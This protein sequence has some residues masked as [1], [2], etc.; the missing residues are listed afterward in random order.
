MVGGVVS[1]VTLIVRLP[2]AVALPASETFN[3][4]RFA[5]RVAEQATAIDAVI[6]PLV[7]VIEEME[8]PRGTEVTVTIRL[9]AGVR[10]SLTVAIVCTAEGLSCWREIVAG[11]ICGG[12]FGGGGGGPLQPKKMGETFFS[13]V[14]TAA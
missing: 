3:P 14:P 1:A 7:L 11:L 13:F 8:M 4:T 2:V 10:S 6:V 12:L 9:P 5:P